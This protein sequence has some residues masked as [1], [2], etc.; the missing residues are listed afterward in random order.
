MKVGFGHVTAAK[1]AI[2]VV[3]GSGIVLL[4]V[5]R[6]TNPLQTDVVADSVVVNKQ[7]RTLLLFTNGTIVKSYSISLGGNP[8]GHKLMEGDQRTPEG[9]YVI[10]YRNDESVCYLSLH[11]TYP[12]SAAVRRARSLNVSPGG[13]IM[14]HGLKNGWGWIGRLH[15]LSDWTDGCIAVTNR[16]MDELWRAA[17]DGVPIVIRP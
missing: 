7:A 17:P 16:E 8:N 10:D 2:G 11:I 13:F 5:N 15:L 12:D 14:I 1:V 4:L 6:H 9:K 3:V